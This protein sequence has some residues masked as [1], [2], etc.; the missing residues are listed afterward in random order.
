[1]LFPSVVFLAYFAPLFLCVHFLLPWKNLTFLLF[2]LA[3][4]YWGETKYVA[5]LLAYIA[6][7]YLFG[8]LIGKYGRTRRGRWAL[9]VGVAA[10]LGML[11]YYK[12]WTFCY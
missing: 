5:V 7:N 9:G 2:S 1:M 11:A 4:F 6:V 12:Y 8:L 10:N 3:F